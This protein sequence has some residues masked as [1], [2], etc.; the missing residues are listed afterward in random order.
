M[1]Y[2]KPRQRV[3]DGRWDFT[4]RNNNDV[5]PEGY[6]QPWS[7]AQQFYPPALESKF[8]SEGHATE[9]EAARCYLQ[10]QLDHG[11]V[12]RPET[13]VGNYQEC[14]FPGCET[15]TSGRAE[16][17]MV[18]RWVLCEKH[19]NRESVEVLAEPP[20]EIISSE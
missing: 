13:K 12:F 5:R 16:V 4:R 7:F 10:Y 6:C 11:L 14:E 2:Y 15:V 9:A 18:G 8:H 17:R 3:S 20:S 1:N 19:Q